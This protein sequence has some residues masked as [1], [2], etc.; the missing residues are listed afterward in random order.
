MRNSL[1]FVLSVRLRL[2]VPRKVLFLC[3]RKVMHGGARY[4]DA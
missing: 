2:A 1:A 4:S 3:R